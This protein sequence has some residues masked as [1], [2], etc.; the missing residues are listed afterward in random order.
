MNIKN[1]VKALYQMSPTL[2]KQPIF[3]DVTTGFLAKWSLSNKHRNFILMTCQNLDVG[4]T[5][6]WLCREE[7]WLQPIRSTTLIWVVTRHPFGISPLI[8]EPLF[9]GGMSNCRLF[10]HAERHLISP[11]SQTFKSHV[12]QLLTVKCK[13]R[14]IF[15]EGLEVYKSYFYL[16]QFHGRSNSCRWFFSEFFDKQTNST[17]KNK[18]NQRKGKKNN[19]QKYKK[20]YLNSKLI[21]VI[22]GGPTENQLGKPLNIIFIIIQNIVPFL[23]GLNPLANSS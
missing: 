23:I 15:L 7:N 21:S 20:V 4:S 19:M 13:L 22:T 5:S 18:L 8:S 3:R 12:K 1:T 9:R 16:V 2:R 10:S 17:E 14:V 11:H 6:D